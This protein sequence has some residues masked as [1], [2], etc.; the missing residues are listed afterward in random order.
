MQNVLS[1]VFLQLEW[2]FDTTFGVRTNRITYTC[3]E[4][5]MVL[6]ILKC[7]SNPNLNSKQWARF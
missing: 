5:F 2:R 6:G 3:N 1:L 4:Y 7:Q